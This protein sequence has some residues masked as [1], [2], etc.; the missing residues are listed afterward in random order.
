MF[1]PIKCAIILAIASFTA[2]HS[3]AQLAQTPP[4][5]NP[6]PTTVNNQDTPTDFQKE[7]LQRVNTLRATGCK[8]ADK[9]M[10]PVSS[11]AWNTQL[12][13]A[14]IRHA[15]DMATHNRFN[16]VGSDGSEVDKRA[17]DA[18]Y[19]WSDIGENIAFGYFNVEKVVLGWINSPGH[20]KQMMNPDFKEM[21]AAQNGTYW[22]QVFGKQL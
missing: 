3:T 11:L 7:M 9:K 21:G 14:A 6:I 20:C 4:S 18:G 19:K 15:A 13:D 8:C 16:H 17:T 22:V 2:C 10:P 12:E 5:Q 1:P